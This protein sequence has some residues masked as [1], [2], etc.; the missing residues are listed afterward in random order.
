MEEIMRDVFL[1]CAIF[2]GLFGGLFAQDTGI[3]GITD[4]YVIGEEDTLAV[5]VWKE[6][7]LSVTGGEGLVVRPDG[8]ISLP[9]INDVRASGKTVEQ[10]R[11]EITAKLEEF[12]EVPP[13]VSVIVLK[14]HG[15]KVIVMGQVVKPNIYALGRPTTVL[16]LL[17]RVGGFTPQAKVKN[18]LIVRQENGQELKFPFNYKDAIKGKNLQQN[19]LLLGGDMVLVP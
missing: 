7:E 13:V 9:L 19:I 15:Q 1:S 18:I 3:G 17:A 5:S 2:L 6:P 4:D 8:K 10:L 12:M 14:A 11:N 16:D